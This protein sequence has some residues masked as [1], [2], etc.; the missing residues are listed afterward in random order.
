MVFSWCLNLC[1]VTQRKTIKKDLL[2][3]GFI[4]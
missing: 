2:Q 1:D 4:H 3:T